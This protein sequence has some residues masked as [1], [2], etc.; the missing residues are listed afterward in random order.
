MSFVRRARNR[1]ALLWD[2]SR[3]GPAAASENPYARDAGETLFVPGALSVRRSSFRSTARFPTVESVEHH[4]RRPADGIRLVAGA[5]VPVREADVPAFITHASGWGRMLPPGERLYWVQPLSNNFVVSVD[6]V[7]QLLGLAGGIDLVEESLTSD[8][9]AC[10]VAA[11]TVRRRECGVALDWPDRLLRDDGRLQRAVGVLSRMPDAVRSGIHIVSVPR[12]AD[13]RW[14]DGMRALLDIVRDDRAAA[15]GV[16]VDGDSG[17]ASPL[18]IFLADAVQL[19]DRVRMQWIERPDA[20]AAGA[21]MTMP[22]AVVP[23]IVCDCSLS[24]DGESAAAPYVRDGSYVP[25]EFDARVPASTPREG[26]LVELPRTDGRGVSIAPQNR[27]AWATASAERRVDA[28]LSRLVDAPID[29]AARSLFAAL[30]LER[31]REYLARLEADRSLVS[32]WHDYHVYNWPAPPRQILRLVAFDAGDLLDSQSTLRAFEHAR[33]R[34]PM[35]TGLRCIDRAVETAVEAVRSAAAIREQQK[36][37]HEYLSDGGRRA[38]SADS[39]QLVARL[40]ATLGST[41]E[42]GFGYGLTAQRVARR[43]SRYVGID[44]RTAQAHALRRAG[45]LGLVADLLALPFASR[46]FDTVIADNV[47]EHA[48]S[49]LGALREIRRVLTPTGR[50]YALVPVDAATNEFQIRTHLWKA[51]ESSVRRAAAVCGFRIV[52]VEMLS[53]S[54]LGVYGCFPA[55]AGR[56]CL[57][58]CEPCAAAADRIAV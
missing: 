47:L 6:E 9:G 56:T 20:D 14:R 30:D 32:R 26:A 27:W 43:A 8:G 29:R 12:P 39:E 48:A 36:N 31:R 45:G 53:Y 37:A 22:T 16:R 50:L 18:A 2:D 42:I 40:P 25:I 28:A 34:I 15:I 10:I 55:S 58:V 5:W 33:T 35:L 54:A 46:R 49:P 24:L 7:E 23:G 38:L 52:D 19:G 4:L 1:I 41:L 11:A 51:D 17:D 3:V 13:E 44:L 57:V 21:A